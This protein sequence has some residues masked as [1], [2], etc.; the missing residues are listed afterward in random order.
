MADAFSSGNEH[1]ASS[2]SRRSVLPGPL[3]SHPRVL[4]R[5][6]LAMRVSMP[7]RSQR[8]SQWARLLAEHALS[9]ALA[10]R[11]RPSRRNELRKLGHELVE[12]VGELGWVAQHR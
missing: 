9:Q 5:G 1:T 7:T 11:E 6:A 12:D 3:G 4:G 2:L 10:R 8:S